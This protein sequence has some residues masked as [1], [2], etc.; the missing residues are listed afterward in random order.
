MFIKGRTHYRGSISLASASSHLADDLNGLVG[1]GV[2]VDGGGPLR[3][4]H[5]VKQLMMRGRKARIQ[6]GRR[7]I[8]NMPQDEH[9]R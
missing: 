9:D 4:M 2:E 5:E 6:T 7:H 1:P 3:R 8:R